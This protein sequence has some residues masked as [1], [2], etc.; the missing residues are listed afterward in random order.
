MTGCASKNQSLAAYLI[1]RGELEQDCKS[2]LDALVSLYEKDI[3]QNVKR[4]VVATLGRHDR[5]RTELERSLDPDARSLV[6]FLTTMPFPGDDPRALAALWM[7][8]TQRT[9]TGRKGPHGP[10]DDSAFY[11]F[12]PK[13]HWARSLSP[14]TRS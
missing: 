3:G 9:R 10:V 6:S 2:A 14:A 12:T 4:T 5:V 1:E 13:E 7:R 11:G 8:A